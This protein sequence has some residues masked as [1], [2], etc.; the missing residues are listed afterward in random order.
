M[1]SLPEPLIAMIREKIADPAR[2]QFGGDRISMGSTSDPEA[3]RS[4]MDQGLEGQDPG[5]PHPFDLIRRQMAEWGQQMPEMHLSMDANGNRSASS[6]RGSETPAPPASE[7]DLAKLERRIG[8]TL[9]EDLR[10]MFGIS[11]GGWGPGY[12]FTQGY[13]AGLMSALGVIEQ[14]DDL[15]RR[16]PGYTAEMD[17]PANLLPLTDLV[18]TTSYDLNSGRI[19][20][21][22]DHWYDHDIT[23][24]EAFSESHPSLQDFL[25]EWVLD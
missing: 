6:E 13:G 5:T 24:E 23:I 18:G 2:R 12:A 16:G 8:R 15:E 19:V 11:D 4:F 7:E 20:Q 22:D 17:W 1:P 3:V 14:L 25:Q 21:F 10:Q 9:P